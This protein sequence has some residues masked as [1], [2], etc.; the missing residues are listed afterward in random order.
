MHII[1]ALLVHGNDTSRLVQGDHAPL[2]F[3]NIGKATAVPRSERFRGR[4]LELLF[5]LTMAPPGTKQKSQYRLTYG[6][7]CTFMLYAR[8]SATLNYRGSTRALRARLVTGRCR[9][10]YHR[11]A[12][13][14]PLFP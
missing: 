8:R 3:T 6:G 2:E 4:T 5:G 12:C 7:T 10:F 11:R 14:L 9:Y 13:L 1:W